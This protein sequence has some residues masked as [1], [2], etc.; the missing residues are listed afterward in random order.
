VG[1][2]ALLSEQQVI[3][4]SVADELQMGQIKDK[5]I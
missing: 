3:P 2:R 4:S 5:T 1:A